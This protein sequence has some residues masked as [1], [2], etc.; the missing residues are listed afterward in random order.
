MSAFRESMFPISSRKSVWRLKI[1]GSILFIGKCPC[2]TEELRCGSSP[3]ATGTTATNVAHPLCCWISWPTDSFRYRSVE[4]MT[5]TIQGHDKLL[6]QCQVAHRLF[7]MISSGE[8]GVDNP[9]NNFHGNSSWTGLRPWSFAPNLTAHRI[10][11]GGMFGHHHK[12][13]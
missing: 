7:L 9:R 11:N 6:R 13:M 4:I 12:D 8:T 10:C 1:A 3:D 5:G 2:V